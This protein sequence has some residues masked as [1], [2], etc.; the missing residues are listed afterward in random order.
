M[1]ALLMLV[2]GYLPYKL[3]VIASPSM[4]GELNEGDAVIYE[5]YEGQVIEE[6]TIV[7]FTRDDE[8]LIVHRVIDA[9]QIDGTVYY[10]TKGDAN[11]DADS[12]FI[13]SEEMRGVVLFRV[14]QVGHLSLWLRDIFL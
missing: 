14:P 3:L 6:N 8:H 10:V 9:E 5:A 7:V 13:T 2:S 1:A 11:T 12:G 4:T